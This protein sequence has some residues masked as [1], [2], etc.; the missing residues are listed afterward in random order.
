MR[1]H[2]QEFADAGARIAAVGLGGT[3]YAIRFREETGITFPLLVDEERIAYRAAELKSGRF[4]HIFL[5]ENMRARARARKGGYQQHA[6]G[7]HP[8]Q[9]GASFVFGE[10][11]RDIFAHVSKFFGDN[12]TPE[13]LLAAVRSFRR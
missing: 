4:W 13:E 7:E 8:F 11:N 10:G 5:P 12:A 9:L 2:Q 3:A 6:L 1:E